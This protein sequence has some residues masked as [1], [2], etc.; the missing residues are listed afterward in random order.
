VEGL[1]ILLEGRGQEEVT[2]PCPRG[3]R[4]VP[5]SVLNILRLLLLS[6]RS[7]TSAWPCELSHGTLLAWYDGFIGGMSHKK[8]S[9]G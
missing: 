9:F 7:S 1:L 4:Q 2:S 6:T 3:S 5:P 8:A